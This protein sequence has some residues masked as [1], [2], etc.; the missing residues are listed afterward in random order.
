VELRLG[1]AQPEPSGQLRLVV[2]VVHLYLLRQTMF[3]LT[4]IHPAQ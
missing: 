2:L 1:M 3:S 4:Q